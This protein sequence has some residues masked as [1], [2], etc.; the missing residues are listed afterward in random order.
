M[1]RSRALLLVCLLWA[2]IYLPGLGSTEIKGEEGRRILPA[3]EMIKTGQWIVPYVGGRPYLRKPPL[4]NWL[5][6]GSFMATDSSNEWAARLPSVLAVLALA[7]VTTLV[8][9]DPK[10]AFLAAGFIL[11]N[12]AMVEKGRLAEIESLYIALSGIAIV[13]WLSWWKQQRSP[14][15]LWIVPSFFLGLALLAKGPLHLLF[16]YSLV[17][18]ALWKAKELKLL[19]HPAHGIGL[20]VA[21]TVFAL[22]AVPY[23]R[24]VAALGPAQVW[25]AQFAGRLTGKFDFLGWITNIPRGLMNFLPWILLAPLFWK[26]KIE[27]DRR[28]RILFT[29]ARGVSVACFFGLLILPGILPRYTLPVMVPLA[30]VFAEAV[31]HTF[32][33]R[34]APFGRFLGPVAL[35]LLVGGLMTAGVCLYAAAIVPRM[36]AVAQL[37]PLARQIEARLPAGKLLYVLDPG[38]MPVLFYLQSPYLCVGELGA[39]PA[40][41]E[42]ALAPKPVLKKLKKQ[43]KTF[44]EM[45][46]WEPK[47]SERMSLLALPVGVP[48][49]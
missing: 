7:L 15:L 25:G 21:A 9:P 35:M 42:F 13:C 46:H 26:V 16:F 34:F 17:V 31:Q 6:A 48:N 37:R 49:R 24:E 1:N 28:L 5:I 22:W 23:F 41:A 14:W 19:W 20:G 18:V 45:A 47:R 38:Y 29:S 40:E 43:K 44:V 27:E 36:N 39:I 2:G 8:V 4:M 33:S 12:I 32:P 30:F 3:L 10:S 11:T